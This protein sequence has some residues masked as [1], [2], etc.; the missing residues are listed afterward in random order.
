MLQK[1]R[2]IK[3]SNLNSTCTQ[4]QN[5]KKTCELYPFGIIWYKKSALEL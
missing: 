1:C 2:N 4:K 3:E 5:Y